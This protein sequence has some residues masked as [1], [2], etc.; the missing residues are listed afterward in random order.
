MTPGVGA[1]EPTDEI[2]AV[3]WVRLDRVGDHLTHPRELVVV[4]GLRMVSASAA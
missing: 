3:R 2:D 1:F 4:R